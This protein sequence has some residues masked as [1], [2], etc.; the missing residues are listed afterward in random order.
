MKKCGLYLILKYGYWFTNWNKCTQPI[1][2]VTSRAKNSPYDLAQFS[3][4]SKTVL[5]I[6]VCSFKDMNKWGG[7]SNLNRV[8]WDCLT[9]EWLQ[10]WTRRPGSHEERRKNV[11]NLGNNMCKPSSQEEPSTVPLRQSECERACSAMHRRERGGKGG[12]GGR[13]PLKTLTRLQ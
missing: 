10:T 2:D 9:G 13:R 8:V 1:Q 7:E 11:E 3:C 5:K 12:R 6:R 4:K